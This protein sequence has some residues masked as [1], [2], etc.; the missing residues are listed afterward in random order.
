M[1]IRCRTLAEHLAA[2]LTEQS[3][4]AF[5]VSLVASVVERPED[6]AVTAENILCDVL[7]L[8]RTSGPS[9]E[10]GRENAVAVRIGI[11]A[12]LG[13]AIGPKPTLDLSALR[14]LV[15]RVV[16]WLGGEGDDS[17]ANFY[18]PPSGWTIGEIDALPGLDPQRLAAR[19]FLS[20][21][22]VELRSSGL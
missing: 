12:K 5:G 17:G 8:G 14:E 6:Q 11:R 7:P 15:D 22:S 20:I 10:A 4:A 9:G 18:E 21:V 2:A 3:A 19:E 13:T 16:D 1:A